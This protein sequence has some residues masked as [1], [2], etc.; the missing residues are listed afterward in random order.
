MCQWIRYLTICLLILTLTG[1]LNVATTGAQ[2]VYNHHSL[3]KTINDQYITMQ[4]YQN[5]KMKTHDFDSANVSISTYEGDV[6]LAGQAP[7]KWQKV[8]AGQIVKKIPGVVS[9]Y[10]QIEIASPSSTLTRISDTWITTKIKSKLIASADVDVTQIKVVTE[11]GVVYLMGAVKP[12][13]AIAAIDIASTTIGVLGVV[14]MFSY[15]HIS[16][17]LA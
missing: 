13:E 7:M 16:K 14:K 11:N 15:V 6:L 9:V 5:L 1:C 3:Q 10:N 8:K 4:A 17:T 12:D 2:A